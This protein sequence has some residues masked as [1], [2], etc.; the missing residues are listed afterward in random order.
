ML[1]A[2]NII[3]I[4]RALALGKILFYCVKKYPTEGF[5]RSKSKYIKSGLRPLLAALN[6]LRA[7]ALGS[8]LFY[9]VKKYRTEGL[10]RSKS[11][12]IKSGLRFSTGRSR[13]LF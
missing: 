12:Y 5:T 10:T 3:N 7:F 4:L 1:V 11:K 2:L 8:V 13:P 9:C 6:I